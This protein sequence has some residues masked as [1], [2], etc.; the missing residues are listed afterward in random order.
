VLLNNSISNYDNECS[1]TTPS[2]KHPF[3]ISSVN[4]ENY[5]QSKNSVLL[6][7]HYRDNYITEFK[8]TEI[9]FGAELGK[10]FGSS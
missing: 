2:Q 3:I 10:Y 4:E 8:M 5:I 6:L 1:I 9:I 7:I